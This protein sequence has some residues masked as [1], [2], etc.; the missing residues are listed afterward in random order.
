MMRPL[1]LACAA[2]GLAA[3]GIARADDPARPPLYYQDPDGKPFYAPGPKQTADGRD[4]RLVFEDGPRPQAAAG[5]ADTPKPAGSG[6][7]RIRY[8]RNPMGLPDTSPKP[9]KDAMGM[10]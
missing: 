4:Y 3:V 2:I 7:H 9:K 1:F 8:Y 6:D 5:P 10:D